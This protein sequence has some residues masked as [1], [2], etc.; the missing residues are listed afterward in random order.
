MTGGVPNATLGLINVEEVTK[1]VP[2]AGRPATLREVAALV[3]ERG[4]SGVPIVKSERGVLGVA[5]AVP[6]TEV[7]RATTEERSAS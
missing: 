4:V 6:T 5:P 2:A 7:S 1:D 3:V